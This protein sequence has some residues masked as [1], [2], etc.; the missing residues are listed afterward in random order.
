MCGGRVVSA[1]C[2]HVCHLER[3]GGRLYRSTWKKQTEAN[4][5]RIAKVWFD[6]YIEQFYRYYP[7]LKVNNRLGLETR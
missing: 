4:Y 7:D 3:S 6:D 2:S 1:P 5:H